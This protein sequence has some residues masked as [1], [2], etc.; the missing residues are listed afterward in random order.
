MVSGWRFNVP[1]LTIMLHLALSLRYVLL[2]ASLGTALGA[3]VMFY[4]GTAKIVLAAYALFKGAEEKAVVAGVMSG[5]DV[6]LF[7]IVLVIFAY[8]IAFGFVFNLT[9][10][11]RKTLPRWMQATSMHELKA[12]L[13]G[14]ILVYLIVDFA[15]DWAQDVGE[16]R[17]EVLT[18][19][20]SI[21][22]IAGAFRLFVV[23][24][25]DDTKSP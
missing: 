3:V 23:N 25:T 19:P 5:T 20:L 11:Q 4:E 22:M 21:L 1:A 9:P 18:K 16:L 10:A 7:G 17:W 14:V 24:H 13:V 15:T 6:F 12:T 8:A 2:V